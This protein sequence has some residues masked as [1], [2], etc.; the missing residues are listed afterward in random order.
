MN[1]DSNVE[2]PGTTTATT[3]ENLL[4][5]QL[6]AEDGQENGG[7]APITTMRIR[8]LPRK[9]VVGDLLAEL[10]EVV[11]EES[12]N[13]LSVPWE[14][15]N[16]SNLGFAFVNFVTADIAT[17]ARD[18]LDG[19]PWQLVDT[20][21]TI[22][23]RPA[24]I[25]GLRKNIWRS[26]EALPPGVGKEQQPIIIVGGRKIAFGVAVRVVSEGMQGEHRSSSGAYTEAQDQQESSG[27]QPI[28]TMMVRNLPRRYLPADLLYE[29][30]EVVS[31]E[32]F[33]FL[34][35][36]WEISNASNLGFG[37]VNFLTADIATTV[38][39][40]MDGRCWK[41][42][43]SVK[44]IRMLPAKIQGLRNNILH[45]LQARPHWTS[46]EHNPIVFLAGKRVSFAA[47]VRA[48]KGG[49]V[50]ALRPSGSSSSKEWPPS[51][52]ASRRPAAGVNSSTASSGQQTTTTASSG[53]S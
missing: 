10:C 43:Q 18:R 49:T 34:S 40:Q 3:D 27:P 15:N 21:K 32:S 7:E 48:V 29:L 4:R 31:E 52:Q 6:E 47:A 24:S 46:E 37:V 36:P 25:Q 42:V 22:R 19:Q 35:V 20:V 30:E 23:M 11:S 38:R 8:N 14:Q 45:S 51:R 41:K 17:R 13:F 44:T 39:D 26:L 50:E 12:L 33:N 53:G 28:T 16:L 1:S 2:K 5:Q 9:Y